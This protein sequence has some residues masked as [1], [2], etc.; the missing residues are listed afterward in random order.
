MIETFAAQ[1]PCA[2]T[3]YNRMGNNEIHTRLTLVLFY[4]FLFFLET[5]GHVRL[6]LVLILL[7]Y[8]A[9]RVEYFKL[10]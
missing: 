2:K 8:Y 4:I 5:I 10:S 1:V 7:S 9:I 3:V 6:R